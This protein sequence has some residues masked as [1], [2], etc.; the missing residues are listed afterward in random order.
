VSAAAVI[1][2]VRLNGADKIRYSAPAGALAPELRAAIQRR[3]LEIIEWLRGPFAELAPLT[4]QAAPYW[5]R[6]LDERRD[7]RDRLVKAEDAGDV[8]GVREILE[9]IVAAFAPAECRCQRVELTYETPLWLTK[10][11]A[12]TKLRD[13]IRALQWKLRQGLSQE[14]PY[15][16]AKAEHETDER[17]LAVRSPAGSGIRHV[18]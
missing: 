13:N 16:L 15:W 17:R 6:V 18:I 14:K 7:L 2:E 12:I 3:R 10:Q 11:Y 5:E 4:K 9:A 1:R 8:H